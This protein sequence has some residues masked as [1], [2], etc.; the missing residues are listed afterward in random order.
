MN[1][2]HLRIGVDGRTVTRAGSGGDW[3][4]RGARSGTFS[5]GSCGCGCNCGL[6]RAWGLVSH[7]LWSCR[8]RQLEIIHTCVRS[9]VGAY[10]VHSIFST[11]SYSIAIAIKIGY[12]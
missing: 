9:G 4:G 11:L 3:G 5:S 12:I 7:W 8:V 1:S 10:T 6:Y 2:L